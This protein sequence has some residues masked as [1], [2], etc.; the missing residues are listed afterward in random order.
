MFKD[1]V[2]ID[3]L[4]KIALLGPVALVWVVINVR[5]VGLR[6]FSKMTAFDFVITV[7]IGSLLATAV[8]TSAWP[9]FLQALG[10]MTALL[11]TQFLISKARS[12]SDKAED[13]ASNDPVWLF[14]DG[15]FLED[16]MECAR[17]TKN[18]LYGK[19]REANALKISEVYG[20]ILETTGDISV[21]HGP[22]PDEAI[23]P[24]RD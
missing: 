2:M 5:I 16:N 12:V 15:K 3:L 21:L 6:S 10:G 7:A 24:A 19:L 20:V 13:V 18:D 17:I 9:A 1:N 23:L 14:R 4:W 11:V 8:T 22:E